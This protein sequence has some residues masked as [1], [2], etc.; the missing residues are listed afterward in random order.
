[1][2][3]YCQKLEIKSDPRGSLLEV[4]K[5]PEWG[6]VFYST[7]K[8]GITRGNHYHTRKLE[9]FCVIEGQAMIRMRNRQ[10]G[11]MIEKKVSGAEPE[12]VDM[13]LGWTH[14]ITNTG[15][16]EMKLLVWISEVYDP[17]DPDT[18]AEEV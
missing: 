17:A 14:N 15:E 8:P 2:E 13:I 11:E 9:K 12:V 1:M 6:Q 7:S 4:F 10:T 3:S 16:G 5:S 18:F